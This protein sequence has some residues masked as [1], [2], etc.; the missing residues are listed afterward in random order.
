[1][2]D[3]PEMTV[4]ELPNDVVLLDVREDDEWSAGRAPDAVHVPLPEVPIRLGELPGADPLYVVCRSG[5]RSALATAWLLEQGRSAVNVAG[6]MKAWAAA[7]RP[8]DSDGP[9]PSIL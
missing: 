1:M 5:V 7:G 2:S 3:V 4:Q 8:L 9:A 6:G